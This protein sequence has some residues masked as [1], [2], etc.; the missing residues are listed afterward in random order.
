[1]LFKLFLYLM[2]AGGLTVLLLRLVTGIYAASRT[3]ALEDAPAERVAIVFGA[4][5]WRDGSPTPVLR[6]RVAT[7]AELY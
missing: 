4:G 1:M 6:D 7:A 2:I 3:H 5:L